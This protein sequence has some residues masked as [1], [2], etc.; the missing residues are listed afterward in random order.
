VMLP[1]PPVSAPPAGAP[2]VDTG[3]GLGEAATAA[4]AVTVVTAA[5]VLVTHVWVGVA[6]A[7]ACVPHDWPGPPQDCVD[8]TQPGEGCCRVHVGAGAGGGV[9]HW[10]CPPCPWPGESTAACAAVPVSPTA[11]APTA[12]QPASTR[13]RNRISRS[14]WPDRSCAVSD[15]E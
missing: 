1:P 13:I 12:K 11:A 7:G 8:G 15:S 5:G 3:D 4:W 6:Q 14:F 2:E 9:E 10:H